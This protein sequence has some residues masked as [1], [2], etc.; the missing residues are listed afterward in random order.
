MISVLQCFAVYCSVLQC[1]LHLERGERVVVVHDHVHELLQSVLQC[2]AVCCSVLQCVAVCC[3]VLQCVAVC[4]A[5][6]RREHVVVHDH[7]H[8]LLQ[9]VLQC[10]EVCCMCY[11]VLPCVAVCC[12]IAVCCRVLQCVAVCCSVLQRVAVCCSA[13]QPSNKLQGVPLKIT[14]EL[15]FLK[16]RTN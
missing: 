11:S 12:S 3:S 8:E 4:V 14:V 1:A 2:V 5:F 15:T 16:F 6:E 13:W 10:A 9:C 7:V